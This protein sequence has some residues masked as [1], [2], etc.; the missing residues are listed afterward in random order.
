MVFLIKKKQTLQD[1]I[2]PPKLVPLREDLSLG[3]FWTLYITILFYPW[4]IFK[5]LLLSILY[6]GIFLYTVTAKYRQL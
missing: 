6:T 5:Y 3:T 2:P 4:T 1:K